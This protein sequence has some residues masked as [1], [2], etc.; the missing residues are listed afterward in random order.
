MYEEDSYSFQGKEG[1]FSGEMA[2][3]RLALSRNRYATSDLRYSIAQG[4]DDVL[5]R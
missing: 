5:M 4:I 1:I 2:P 3:L